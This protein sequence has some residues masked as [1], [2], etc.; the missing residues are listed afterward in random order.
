MKISLLH[1]DVATGRQIKFFRTIFALSEVIKRFHSFFLKIYN[2][3]GLKWKGGRFL[4][5]HLVSEFS[6]P[7]KKRTQKYL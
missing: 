2:I 3:L 7:Q 4:N 6:V 1:I 5:T